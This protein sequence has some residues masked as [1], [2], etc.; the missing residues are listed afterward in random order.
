[1]VK[2]KVHRGRKKGGSLSDVGKKALAVG[3]K[4]YDTGKK[5]DD[6]LRKTKII[7]ST[8]G[9]M[10]KKIR[11][12]SIVSQFGYG[13]RKR[14]TRRRKKGGSI[15]GDILGKIVSVPLGGVMGATQG[16]YSGFKGLGKQSGGRRLS[17]SV[18]ANDPIGRR[19]SRMY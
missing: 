18:M 11:P 1:M 13:K 3:K 9:F 17:Y 15:V 4:V 14:R 6:L 10:G 5:V 8:L 12:E 2:R 19:F 16:V 7:S